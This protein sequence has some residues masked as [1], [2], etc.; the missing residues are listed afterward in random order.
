[1]FRYAEEFREKVR[2]LKDRF[3]MA[4]SMK[5]K[6]FE[7]V[8]NLKPLA[9]FFDDSIIIFALDNNEGIF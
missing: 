9:L 2:R 8:T 5:L 4:L 3:E 6:Q 7:M 1:V